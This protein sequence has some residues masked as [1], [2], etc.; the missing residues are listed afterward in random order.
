MFLF[1]CCYTVDIISKYLIFWLVYLKY[2]GSIF[3]INYN[4]SRLKYKCFHDMTTRMSEC[5]NSEHANILAALG[6]KKMGIKET[7]T[8]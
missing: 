2:D 7:S 8:Y 5:N 4:V 1:F 3:S 6:K